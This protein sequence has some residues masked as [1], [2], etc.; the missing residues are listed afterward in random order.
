MRYFRFGSF[1]PFEFKENGN[2]FSP[3]IATD[4]VDTGV[5]I[6]FYDDTIILSK[7]CFD[8]NEI[9][10][11]SSIIEV[12]EEEWIRAKTLFMDNTLSKY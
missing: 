11:S 2:Y 6:A 1:S 4:M 7:S 3:I 10:N 8:N 9:L 5:M 12:G